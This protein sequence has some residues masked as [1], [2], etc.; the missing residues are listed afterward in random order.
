MNHASQ[1]LCAVQG[2]AIRPRGTD[3]AAG[4][5]GDDTGWG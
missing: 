4:P 2:A 3:A 1:K 5:T